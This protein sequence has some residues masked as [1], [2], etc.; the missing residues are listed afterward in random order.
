MS[1]KKSKSQSTKNLTLLG[2]Q[3]SGFPDSPGKAKLET[4]PNPHPKKD[5][6]VTF[7]CPEFTAICPKTHQP[8]FG[9]INIRYIPGQR[10]LEAKSLKLY[11]FSYRNMGIFNEDAVNCILKDLVQV[12]R[13]REMEVRGDFSPRGGI[14]ISVAASFSK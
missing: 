7:D 12:L 8:D 5:Y 4:F 6:W 9:I 10:C 2:K 13:P 3:V 1:Q 14:C 11:L